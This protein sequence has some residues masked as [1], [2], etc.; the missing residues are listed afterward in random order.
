MN[1]TAASQIRKQFRLQKRLI[2]NSHGCRP[3]EFLWIQGDPEEGRCRSVRLSYPFLSGLSL[4]SER[5]SFVPLHSDLLPVC[6]RGISQAWSL[7]GAVSFSP[8]HSP[9]SPMGRPRLRSG[10]VKNPSHDP[11]E[12]FQDHCGTFCPLNGIEVCQS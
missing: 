11:C 4:A 12:T 7:Q 8:T 5:R 1:A 3:S 10:A 6:T 9:L 2:I